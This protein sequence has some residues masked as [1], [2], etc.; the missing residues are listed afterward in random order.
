[1]A[2]NPNSS[3][4][5][6]N[7]LLYPENAHRQTEELD[8]GISAQNIIGTTTVNKQKRQYVS[9]IELKAEIRG[10]VA[11]NNLQTI[12]RL[13]IYDRLTARFGVDLEPRRDM[14]YEFI[15]GI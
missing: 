9:D 15:K 2:R 6:K 1:M 14:I 7:H 11:S 8:S 5:K 13:E 3:I 10:V 12:S 4:S